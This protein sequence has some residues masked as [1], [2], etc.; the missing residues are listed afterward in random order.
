[1]PEPVDYEEKIVTFTAALEAHRDPEADAAKQNRLLKACIERI[2]YKRDKPRRITREEAE[3]LGIQMQ[4]GG[5]WTAPEIELD[6][7]L[8]V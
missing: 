8:R 5:K 7:K 4:V 2:D 1:M 6:V 3:K